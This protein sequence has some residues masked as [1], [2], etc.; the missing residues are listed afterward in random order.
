MSGDQ[1]NQKM[2]AVK[3]LYLAQQIHS[4]QTKKIIFVRLNTFGLYLE[5]VTRKFK[6]VFGEE[7]LS[8]EFRNVK[9]CYLW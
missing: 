3:V 7:V 8:F 6:I 4:P 9:V 1:I 2:M 5:N